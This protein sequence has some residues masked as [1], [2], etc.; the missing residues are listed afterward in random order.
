MKNF[1]EVIE[2]NGVEHKLYFI[3]LGNVAAPDVKIEG[4]GF[5]LSLK[6]SR[7]EFGR[8]AID[9]IHQMPSTT[10]QYLDEF[11]KKV[12]KIIEERI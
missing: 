12:N 1:N 4:E 9:K 3:F 11:L 5:R 2:L 8:F 10:N 6:N 7:N